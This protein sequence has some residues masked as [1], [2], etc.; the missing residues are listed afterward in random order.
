MGYTQNTENHLFSKSEMDTLALELTVESKMYLKRLPDLSCLL[1]TVN[2]SGMSLRWFL[3]RTN[4]NLVE[5]KQRQAWQ[6]I[7]S[8]FTPLMDLFPYVQYFFKKDVTSIEN[9]AALHFKNSSVPV[10]P[11]LNFGHWHRKRKEK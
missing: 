7:D 6:G 3:L 4:G 5:I 2:I 8:S 11:D 10:K 1:A 9:S